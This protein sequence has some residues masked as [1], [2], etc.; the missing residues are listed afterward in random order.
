M[1]GT[2]EGSNVRKYKQITGQKDEHHGLHEHE[3][4]Q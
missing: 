1:T 3:G 2:V 4:L